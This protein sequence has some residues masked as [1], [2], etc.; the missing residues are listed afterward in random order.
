MWISKLK[1]LIKILVLIISYILFMTTMAHAGVPGGREES[2]ANVRTYGTGVVIRAMD[3]VRPGFKAPKSG[4]SDCEWVIRIADDFEDSV[5]ST[6]I[7]SLAYGNDNAKKLGTPNI[8]A[9]YSETGRWWQRDCPGEFPQVIPE[10]EPVT[11]PGLLAMAIDEI[12]PGEPP[13][14][15]DPE[16]SMKLV[17]APTILSIDPAYWTAR[18]KTVSAG[19]VSVTATLDPYKSVWDS[20]EPDADS[21]VCSGPG[22]AYVARSDWKKYKCAHV[23][24]WA[25]PPGEYYT[26][27][28]SAVFEITATS[29]TPETMGPYEDL[30]IES[31]EQVEVGELHALVKKS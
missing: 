26:M 3:T 27:T 25:P 28:T 9:V 24:K 31:T 17:Q 21:V 8:V 4:E 18:S 6:S 29:N 10:G 16:G 1:Y 5:W 19:R 15:S 23:Y 30:A 12:K 11:V 7:G 14:R 2:H 13:T 22:K 20:G